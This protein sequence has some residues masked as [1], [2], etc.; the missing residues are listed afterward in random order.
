MDTAGYNP[1]SSLNSAD[2][3]SIKDTTT[4]TKIP[5]VGQFM[6]DMMV[7][8]LACDKTGVI[9][10]QW[11]DTEAKHTFPWLNLS[12]HHH[13]YQHDGGFRPTECATIATWY[14]QMHLSLIQKMQQVD[15]GGHTLLDESL[16]FFGSELSV[17]DSHGKNNM[18]FLLAGGDGKTVKTGRWIKCGGVPHNKLLTAILNVYG[19]T[20]TTFGAAGIDSAALKAPTGLT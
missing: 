13:F 3:G 5:I 8:A 14:S 9:S 10:L 19:D 2:D 16:I 7:M 17:P 11:T 20:R 18:P 12:E 15:M 1:S 4:D 6:M